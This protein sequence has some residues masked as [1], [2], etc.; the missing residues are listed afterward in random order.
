MQLRFEEAV[1][2]SGIK[3]NIEDVVKYSE[4]IKYTTDFALYN[5]GSFYTCGTSTTHLNIRPSTL[6]PSPAWMDGVD[7]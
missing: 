1:K 4:P 5:S 7:S 2:Y 6:F 3:D